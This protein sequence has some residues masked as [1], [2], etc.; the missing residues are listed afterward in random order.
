MGVPKGTRISEMT[1]WTCLA[2]RNG[3]SATTSPMLSEDLGSWTRW[4]EWSL[5][6]YNPGKASQSAPLFRRAKEALAS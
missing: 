3:R 5:K 6:N 2:A 4:S 1:W